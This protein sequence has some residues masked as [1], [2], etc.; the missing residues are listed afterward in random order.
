M[1][2]V[3]NVQHWLRGIVYAILVEDIANDGFNYVDLAGHVT[4]K[5]GEEFW[6]NL[7]LTKQVDLVRKALQHL[8]AQSGSDIQMEMRKGLAYFSIKRKSVKGF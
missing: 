6:S 4:T 7:T 2:Q 1:T 8:R 3:K 5:S